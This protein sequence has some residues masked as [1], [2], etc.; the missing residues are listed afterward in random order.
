MDSVWLTIAINHAEIVGAH[1]YESS[2]SMHHSNEN[3]LK[4]LWWCCIV[5]DRLASLCLG[6]RTQIDAA[7]FDASSYRPFGISDLRNEIHHSQVFNATL[8]SHLIGL[9]EKFL[10]LC[11]VLSSLFHL[12]YGQAQPLPGDFNKTLEEIVAVKSQLREWYKDISHNL[13][14]LIDPQGGSPLIK[15][16]EDISIIQ[17]YFNTVIIY[18]W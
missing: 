8:K 13:P 9:L 4:R 11:L 6:R 18:Y 12:A 1:Q 5:Q 17:L 3:T 7:R 10:H 14:H 16:E 15:D 2:L